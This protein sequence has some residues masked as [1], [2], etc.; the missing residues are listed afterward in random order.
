VSRAAAGVLVAV[1]MLGAC[2]GGNAPSK[3]D[4]IASADRICDAARADAAPLLQRLSRTDPTSLGG[5][6]A[7]R[8]AATT[9]QLHEIGTGMLADLRALERP[10][11]DRKALDDFMG[12]TTELVKTIGDAADALAEANAAAALSSLGALGA[13]SMQVSAS[14]DAY[15]FKRCGQVVTLTG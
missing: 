11:Q 4:Y 13:T 9:E 3:A 8:L 14:A 1:L 6:R 15:G 10:T 12:A 7:R 2:G 5:Q